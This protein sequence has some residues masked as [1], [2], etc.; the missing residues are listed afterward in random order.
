MEIQIKNLKEMFNKELE[1]FKSKM[2]STIAE[3]KNTQERTNSRL[4][5][6]EEQISV[7]EGRV[8]ESTATE[9]NKE[10]KE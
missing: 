4:T 7:V 9:K 10:K 3:M 8:V 5:E 6:A 1:D 2:N